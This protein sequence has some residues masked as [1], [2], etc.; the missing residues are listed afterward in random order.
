MRWRKFASSVDAYVCAWERVC[1]VFIVV[2]NCVTLW[3]SK[4]Y[5]ERINDDI[6]RQVSV[7]VVA[8]SVPAVDLPCIERDKLHL[9]VD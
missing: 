2:S 1:L 6:I 3:T 5:E 9:S 8:G 4:L 7:V